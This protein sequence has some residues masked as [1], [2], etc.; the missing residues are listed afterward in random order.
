MNTD[1]HAGIISKE[2]FEAVE[3]VMPAISNVE[4]GEDG[5][6]IRNKKKL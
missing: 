1:R 5:I 2:K 6:I 4:L 3:I